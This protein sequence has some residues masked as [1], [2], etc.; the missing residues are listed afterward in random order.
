M[1]NIIPVPV[2]ISVGVPAGPDENG[3]TKNFGAFRL[4]PYAS[5]RGGS[6]EIARWMLMNSTG[7]IEELD[8]V[9]LFS[10]LPRKLLYHICRYT[11]ESEREHMP[12][13]ITIDDQTWSYPMCAREL[14]YEE[15]HYMIE[16]HGEWMKISEVALNEIL[17]EEHY[18]FCERDAL[19]TIGFGDP[20]AVFNEMG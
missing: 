13:V 18:M 5:T 20:E 10:V 11:F 14:E 19:P 15:V 7:D 12:L 1:P 9:S 17:D 16:V 8:E 3:G 2:T 4:V 6:L